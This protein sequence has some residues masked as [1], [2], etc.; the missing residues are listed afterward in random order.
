ME[1]LKPIDGDFNR[2]GQ[3][4]YVAADNRDFLLALAFRLA[5]FFANNIEDVF[6]Y[7]EK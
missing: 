6:D 2:I 4:R 1:V 5:R 3:M 7:I